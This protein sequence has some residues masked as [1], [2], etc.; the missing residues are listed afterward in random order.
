MTKLSRGIFVVLE[1]ADRVGKTTQASLL[2]KALSDITQKETLSVKFPDRDTPLGNHLSAYL[3]GTGDINNHALHLLFTANRWERQSDIRQAISDGI[4]VVADRYIYSGIAYTAAK[5]H[6]TPNWEWC[7]KMEKGLVAPDLVIC[8][9]PENLDDLNSRN[10]YGIERY[11]EDDFQ[12]RVLENYIR[13]SK[14]VQL[15]NSDLEN[16]NDD[17]NESNP[18]GFWHFIQAT[19]KSIDEVHQCI[20]ALVK[21][22]LESMSGPEIHDCTKKTN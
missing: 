7:C 14:E 5:P 11:E 8:L 15:E 13:I 9:T 10:G 12:K 6:S 3:N 18:I 19:N 22:K 21:L 16:N 4:P 1:G 17:D 20:M 2:A